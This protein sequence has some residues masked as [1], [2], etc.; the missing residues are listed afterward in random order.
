MGR[1]F[2]RTFI[3]TLLSGIGPVSSWTSTDQP[4]LGHKRWW[5]RIPCINPFNNSDFSSNFFAITLA[6]GN[7]M[8][9]VSETRT[10]TNIQFLAFWRGYSLRILDIAWFCSPANHVYSVCEGVVIRWCVARCLVSWRR[11]KTQCS[12]LV[13]GTP[14]HIIP[15]KMNGRLVSELRD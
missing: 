11:I 15:H 5:D 3:A 4:L 13:P 8:T 6:C 2:L 9:R 7:N 10:H 1:T 12:Q 14:F